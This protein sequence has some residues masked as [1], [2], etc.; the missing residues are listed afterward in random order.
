MLAFTSVSRLFLISLSVRIINVYFDIQT[1]GVSFK[2]DIAQ[3]L[4]RSE[5]S[6]EFDSN[7]QLKNMVSYVALIL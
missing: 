5:S 2:L 1:L 4:R 6:P 3:G 7:R